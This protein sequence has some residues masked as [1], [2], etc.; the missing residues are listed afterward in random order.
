L[1]NRSR[2]QFPKTFWLAG[3][4]PSSVY[5]NFDLLANTLALKLKLGNTVQQN[6]LVQEFK[7]RITQSQFLLASFDPVIEPKMV[8]FWGL[9]E[10][11]SYSFRNHPGH[12]HNG[13]IWP[14]WNGLLAQVLTDY[15][16]DTANKLSDYLE[17]ACKMGISQE[18]EFNECLNGMTHLPNGVPKCSWSAAGLILSR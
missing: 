5:T 7:N 12:F 2:H 10:I 13:G 9:K 14:V 16:L 15:D 6:F 3:F 11:Y 1:I 17:Q 8:E 18:W 4:N